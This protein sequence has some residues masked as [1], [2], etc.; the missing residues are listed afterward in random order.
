[1]PLREYV[2]MDAPSPKFQDLVFLTTRW[3]EYSYRGLAEDSTAFDKL[4]SV[5]TAACKN[6][7]PATGRFPLVL[8]SAGWF[9]RS[10][11]N[12]I[13]A[14]FLAS[15]GFVVA[16]VPQLNPGLWTF[17]FSSDAMSVENQIRDLEYVVGMLSEKSYV[18]RRSIASMGYSTG[19]DVA[20]LL[21]GRNP[22]IDAVVGLDA[23]WTIS[24]NNDV[25]E[26]QFFSP[27]QHTAPILAIRRPTEDS[28]SANDILDSLQLS[29][30][31]IAEI[32]GG[33]HGSFSDDPSQRRILGIQST[34]HYSTHGMIAH[35]VLDFLKSK[36]SSSDLSNS[37][38][39]QRFQDRGLDSHYREANE[40]DQKE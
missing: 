14:E 33:N 10:P 39:V 12:T 5:K 36:L 26:S 23:S 40:I 21:Q 29:P 32:P 34:S 17:N 28:S 2:F 37:D 35:T 3:D 9:N 27:E 13:L 19:G 7:R 1:M 11:D 15:H 38:L 30:R 4:M 25:I 8:Y 18:D 24:N 16:T 20:L 22:L 6:A 31:I